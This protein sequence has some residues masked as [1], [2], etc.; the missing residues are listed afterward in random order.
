MFLKSQRV[1]SAGNLDASDSEIFKHK[2]RARYP[3]VHAVYRQYHKVVVAVL[4]AA[5]VGDYKL[6][7]LPQ[8][9]VGRDS[10][11]APFLCKIFQLDQFFADSQLK[12]PLKN[13]CLIICALIFKKNKHSMRKLNF[14]K[15]LL[16]FDKKL[17]TNGKRCSII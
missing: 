15:K 9:S 8:V 14:N 17:L 12:F 10:D 16:F 5:A 4:D 2:R 7:A 6:R 1:D 11:G 3:N 13:T